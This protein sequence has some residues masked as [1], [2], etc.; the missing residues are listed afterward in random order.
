MEQG[1]RLDR[2]NRY[3]NDLLVDIIQARTRTIQ[4]LRSRLSEY[5]EDK[6]QNHLSLESQDNDLLIESSLVEELDTVDVR[7]TKED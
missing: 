7:N 1:R 3:N 5:E 2:Y 6:E 4:Q